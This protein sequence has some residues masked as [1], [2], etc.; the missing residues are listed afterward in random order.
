MHWYL[1]PFGNSSPILGLAP[2]QLGLQCPGLGPCSSA[3]LALWQSGRFG[4]GLLGQPSHPFA[5]LIKRPL[6]SW[7]PSIFLG[8]WFLSLSGLGPTECLRA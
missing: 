7:T 8:F 2:A 5:K 6:G 3:S 1:M 4:K